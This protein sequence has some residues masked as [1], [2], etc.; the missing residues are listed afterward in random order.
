MPLARKHF[1]ALVA[2]AAGA[3]GGDNGPAA[4]SDP[5]QDEDGDGFTSD[6]DCRD[7]NPS[8]HPDAVEVCDNVDN[9]CDG[10]IDEDLATEW[11]PDADADGFGDAATSIWA[12]TRPDGAVPNGGDCDD[13]APQTYPGA[14]EYC[15]GIDNDCDGQADPTA[16][17]PLDSADLRLDGLAAGQR[18]GQV[19]VG[20]GDLDGDGHGGFGVGAPGAAPNGSGSGAIWL[21]DGPL[22]DGADLGAADAVFE[23]GSLGDAVGWSLATA[24]DVDGD[25]L[26]DLILGAWG[27]SGAGGEAGAAYVMLS[28]VLGVVGPDQA[29]AR[30]RGEQIGDSAGLSVAG[31]DEVDGSGGVA[32][33]IGAPNADDGA[34][35][36]GAAY[37]ILNP[38]AGT[39]S[40]GAATA[41]LRGDLES[42]QV[43]AAVTRAGDLDGDGITDFAVAAPGS[44]LNGARSG[45]VYIFLHSP[46]GD[47]PIGD[48]A[49]HLRLGGDAG[50][51]AGTALADFGDLDGD[52]Y[53]ELLVGAP[54]QSDGG[55]G[56]GAAYLVKGPPDSNLSLRDAHARII[57]RLPQDHAGNAL[58]RAG[59]VNGD[60]WPDLIVGAYIEDSGGL[61]AG[62]AFLVHGPITGTRYLSDADAGF[63]GEAE[64]DLA[65]WSVAGVG[66]VDADGLDDVL[67]GAPQHDRGG[68]QA[69]VAYL[70]YAGGL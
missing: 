21:F 41:R 30:F 54:D 64:S 52:G 40:L 25:G 32:L 14:P 27:E 15:D 4:T 2:L 63:I 50:D 61:N 20:L 56:A 29:W 33:L 31:L 70:L 37:F 17:R 44:D 42:E 9:D 55:S 1:L 66:D 68:D 8:I 7:D 47:A 6:V 67:V 3:C 58:D 53:D 11:H 5:P 19:V 24:G 34:W 26:E 45:A 23:G 10:T 22:A 38:T 36:S 46:S 18:V 48:L 65:G 13:T 62:S 59:D 69:G 28:P 57:G 35:S 60:G 51:Q 39:S 43:G 49:D 16:C 12:C